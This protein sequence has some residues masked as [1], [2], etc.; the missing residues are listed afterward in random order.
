MPE[1]ILICPR[2]QTGELEKHCPPT[3]R[4]GWWS[5]D[6]PCGFRVDITRGVSVVLRRGK[7]GV[8]SARGDED[9]LEEDDPEG[10]GP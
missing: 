3:N 4:C 6:L 9:D 8:D 1:E 10:S 7:E 2:C 5:C